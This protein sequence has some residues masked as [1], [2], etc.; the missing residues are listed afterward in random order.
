MFEV[1]EV[2]SGGAEMGV[3][4]EKNPGHQQLHWGLK[5]QMIKV[6][7]GQFVS[8]MQRGVIRGTAAL[9]L[10]LGT[11]WEH[12]WN[13]INVVCSCLLMFVLL[14]IRA[15][16]NPPNSDGNGVDEKLGFIMFE[17]GLEGILLKVVKRSQFEKGES[18]N[19][20]KKEEPEAEAVHAETVRSRDE[21]EEQTAANSAPGAF[22]CVLH[23]RCALTCGAYL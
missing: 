3:Y 10:N 1:Q 12:S 2:I 9:I 8:I 5:G 15:T 21:L 13:L 23:N 7:N 16:G 22:V 17:C 6:D 18:R 19:E 11:R 4:N 20:T 14:Q